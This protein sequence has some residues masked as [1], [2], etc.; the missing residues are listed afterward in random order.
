MLRKSPRKRLDAA[1]KREHANVTSIVFVS[2]NAR[3]GEEVLQGEGV[4][5]MSMTAVHS[6]IP[7][8]LRR[9]AEIRM[10]IAG[11]LHDAREIHIYLPG[12]LVEMIV[13]VD[14]ARHDQS[15][16]K[17]L[18]RVLTRCLLHLAGLDA[19]LSLSRALPLQDE[20]TTDL[21]LLQL[22]TST[23]SIGEGLQIAVVVTDL[24]LL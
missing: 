12:Q 4:V 6:E 1:S 9:V 19:E 5:V 18:V 17:S 10:S 7:D 15:L 21:Q 16:E 22:T 13:V 14:H 2:E 20:A 11:H 23:I 24:T 8:H 3:R